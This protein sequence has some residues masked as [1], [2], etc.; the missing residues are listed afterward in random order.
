MLARLSVRATLRCAPICAYNYPK[1]M[2]LPAAFSTLARPLMNLNL[3]PWFV[4]PHMATIS[5]LPEVAAALKDQD[6]DTFNNA[7]RITNLERAVEIFELSGRGGKEHKA[8]LALL[9]QAQPPES[10]IATLLTLQEFAADDQEHMN[11]SFA[12]GK[13]YWY[14]G[15]VKKGFELCDSLLEYAIGHPSLLYVCAAKTG[16]GINRLMTCDNADVAF[17]ALDPLRFC[18][19]RTER[20]SSQLQ[21]AVVLYNFGTAEAIHI[22]ALRIINRNRGW[23]RCGSSSACVPKN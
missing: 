21:N 4:T 15:D 9:A 12:L 8:A 5:Q 20:C 6:D 22:T 17:T 16:F 1:R 23:N 13:T 7:E 19:L 3:N 2:M 14:A 11:I 10:A 18:K